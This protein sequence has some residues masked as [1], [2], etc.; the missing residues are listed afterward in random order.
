MNEAAQTFSYTAN[1][2]FSSVV[3]KGGPGAITYSGVTTGLRAPT[4]AET[5]KYD[6]LSRVCVFGGSKGGKR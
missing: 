5:G 1:R 2:T 4:N 6:G 3:V